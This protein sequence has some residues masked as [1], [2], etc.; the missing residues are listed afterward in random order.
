MDAAQW[1]ESDQRAAA[2]VVAAF[3][4]RLVSLPEVLEAA[5]RQSKARRRA[6]VL[7]VAH[8]AGDG[9]HSLPEVEF[10]R[11]CRRAGPASLP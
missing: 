2:V 11:L 4:Q 6:L 8:D 5:A 1:A 3:Q 10:V 7:D 9:A